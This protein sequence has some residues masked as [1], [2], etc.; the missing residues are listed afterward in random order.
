MFQPSSAATKNRINEAAPLLLRL[1][2]PETPPRREG[3]EGLSHARKS[4]WASD[5]FI[6]LASQI[7]PLL[8]TRSWRVNF[9]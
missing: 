5:A 8:S 1:S 2:A 6:N 3:I 7:I 4:L 9:F